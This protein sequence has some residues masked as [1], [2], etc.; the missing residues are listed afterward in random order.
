MILLGW[1]SV[2]FVSGVF[3]FFGV[4]NCWLNIFNM[5]FCFFFFAA[6]QS[7]QKEVREFRSSWFGSCKNDSGFFFFFK[8]IN[9]IFDCL[10]EG[11][12]R[13]QKTHKPKKKKKWFAEKPFFFAVHLNEHRFVFRRCDPRIIEMINLIQLVVK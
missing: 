1:W 4:F 5:R 12:S 6:V 2:H 10:H 9:L 3:F 7:C 13:M 11:R 8:R